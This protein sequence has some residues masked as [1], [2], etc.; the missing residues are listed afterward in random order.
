MTGAM[1]TRDNFLHNW[2]LQSGD[3]WPFS[4]IHFLSMLCS[5]HAEGEQASIE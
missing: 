1:A 4:E 3:K 5:E 2:F